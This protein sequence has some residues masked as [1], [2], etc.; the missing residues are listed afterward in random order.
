[1]RIGDVWP[2]VT[3][4]RKARRN[5]LINQLEVQLQHWVEERTLF[6]LEWELQ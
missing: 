4:F 5:D 2:A 1:M 6:T 3:D